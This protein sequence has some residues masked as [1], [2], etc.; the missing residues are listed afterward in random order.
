MHTS[1]SSKA[2]HLTAMGFKCTSAPSNLLPFSASQEQPHLAQVHRLPLACRSQLKQS[3]PTSTRRPGEAQLAAS[4]S[5]K[6]TLPIA[7]Q[8]QPSGAAMIAGLRS[9]SSSTAS[10]LSPEHEPL[11]SLGSGGSLSMHQAAA[12]HDAGEWPFTEACTEAFTEAA[13]LPNLHCGS[14]GDCTGCARA[15]SIDLAG[16]AC[17]KCTPSILHCS[18]SQS[19]T[20]CHRNAS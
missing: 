2:G 17:T 20:N 15:S 18:G 11:S 16:S 1:G 3:C 12:V 13:S 14:P 8:V 10:L 7:C 5:L 4:G 19:C 9:R 6:A